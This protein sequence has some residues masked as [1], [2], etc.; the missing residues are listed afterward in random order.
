MAPRRKGTYIYFNFTD[1]AIFGGVV[2][3]GVIKRRAVVAL[4]PGTVQG[5]W[6]Q[7]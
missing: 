4:P 2:E 5:G 3:K 1:D 7:P 6:L